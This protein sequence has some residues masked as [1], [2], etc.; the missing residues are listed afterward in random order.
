MILSVKRQRMRWNG[1]CWCWNVWPITPLRTPGSV[2]ES[3]GRVEWSSREEMGVPVTI[4]VGGQFGSEGKGKVAHWLSREQDATYA[5]RVG[6]P[7]S[8]H[9]AVENGSDCGPAPFADTRPDR[10]RYWC[11]SCGGVCRH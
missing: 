2:E 6:G 9:T 11:N 3:R 1:M 5:I 4:V 7:N 10:R 8:G